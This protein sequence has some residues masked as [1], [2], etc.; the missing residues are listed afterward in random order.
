MSASRVCNGPP[1]TRRDHYDFEPIDPGEIVGVAREDGPADPQLVQPLLWCSG[2]HRPTRKFFAFNRQAS[3]AALSSFSTDTSVSTDNRD[4]NAARASAERTLP[5]AQAACARTNGSASPSAAESTGTASKDAQLP[6]ATQ[7]LRANPARPTR[8]I[9]EPLENESHAASSSAVSS[10]AMSDGEAVP[11]CDLDAPDSS[12][13]PNG[14]SPGPRAA[15]D[16][17]VV[18]FENVRVNG[19]HS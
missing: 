9:A 7:M 3:S 12:C 11:G 2:R 17:S 14:D 6:S 18:G 8:R 10:N 16:G 1:A 13:T 4:D 15:N 19:Q 5:S